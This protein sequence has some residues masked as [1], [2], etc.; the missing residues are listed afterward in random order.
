MDGKAFAS[1]NLTACQSREVLKVA[2]SQVQ[3]AERLHQNVFVELLSL[4]E[5]LIDE[6][7]HETL[8]GYIQLVAASPF[9]VHAYSADQFILHAPHEALYL[10]STGSVCREIK[11]QNKRVFYYS[12]VRALMCN[13]FYLA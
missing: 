10:D 13:T 5:I 6:I 12:L 8:P 3:A 7:D 4:K 2:S 9:T 11:G 1:R